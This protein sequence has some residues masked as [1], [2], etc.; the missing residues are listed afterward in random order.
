MT[1]Q[2]L[3]QQLAVKNERLGLALTRLEGKG[4]IEGACNG[5]QL[6]NARGV[7]RSLYSV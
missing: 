1:R 7:P 3:R 4:K 5:W 6:A 2:A